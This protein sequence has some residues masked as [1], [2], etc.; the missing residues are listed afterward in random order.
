MK[1]YVVVENP[2]SSPGSNSRKTEFN[3]LWSALFAVEE[4]Q[5]AFVLLYEEDF[6]GES[7]PAFHE[8]S[9]F[10]DMLHSGLNLGG[11]EAFNSLWYLSVNWLFLNPR[12]D[13]ISTSWK[14][15]PQWCTIRPDQVR[16]MGGFDRAYQSADAALMDFAYRLLLSGGRVCHLPT[17]G[18]TE[19][20]VKINLVD[21]LLFIIRRINKRAAF[22][23]SFW[24]A[25]N[26]LRF[27]KTINLL[28]TAIKISKKIPLPESK[29][30]GQINTH[31][32]TETDHQKVT[33]ISAIIPTIGRYDYVQKSID[34]LLSQDPAPDEI[35]VIDQTPEEDRDLEVYSQYNPSNVRVFFLDEAGQS[36]ARNIGIEHAKYEW[37]LLFEDDAA[38]WEDMM[39]NHVEVIEHSFAS[40]STGVSLAPWKDR[41]YIP[42][43]RRHFQI[44]NV[45]STGICLIKKEAM[46][47]VNYLDRAYDKG[48]GAD[49][50]LGLRLYLN[51]YE[52]IFN[53][54]AIHTHYKAP[55]GGLRTYGVFWRN[56]VK[57]F[58]SYPQPTLIYTTQRFYPRKYWMAQ[59]LLYYFNAN[60]N[61]LSPALIWL[62]LSMPIRLMR[63]LTKAK[64]LHK[65]RS[66]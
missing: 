12:A 3:D 16:D 10:F 6:W 53:P 56:T 62:W 57:W 31:L 19:A 14:A 46:A 2:S 29:R 41:T 43:D 33:K 48:S 47:A 8:E 30:P 34:S 22:Y 11:G 9:Q 17:A 7:L 20:E 5:A 50:D 27:L 66:V 23:T 36:I 32:I 39:E 60:K 40:A 21:E 25:I 26:S 55:R 35:L 28:R 24:I 13:K 45:F 38:A 15:T 44:S 4:S 52:I 51:G 42:E 18:Y 64:H 1:N 59:H 37:I 65:L 54:K 61:K 58:G 63:S 49:H